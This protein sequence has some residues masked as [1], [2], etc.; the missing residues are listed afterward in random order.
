MGVRFDV[1]KI[2][3][4]INTLCFLSVEHNVSS[5]IVLQLLVRLSATMP[6]GLTIM[7]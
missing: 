4:M 1:S 2:H 6:P 5:E 7:D 3:T